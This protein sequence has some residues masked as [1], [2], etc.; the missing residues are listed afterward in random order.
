MVSVMEMFHNA[1]LHLFS[2]V[3]MVL[4]DYLQS[5]VMQC[6]ASVMFAGIYYEEMESYMHPTVIWS[7]TL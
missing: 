4:A 6:V 1:F 3:N 5:Q 7:N 2:R